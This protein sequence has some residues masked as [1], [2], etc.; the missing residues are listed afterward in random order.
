[1]KTKEELQALKSEVEEVS[2]KLAELSDDELKEVCGGLRQGIIPYL[3][4]GILRERPEQEELIVGVVG[5]AEG[6]TAIF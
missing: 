1:M 4:A 5:D 3:A 2:S 6:P